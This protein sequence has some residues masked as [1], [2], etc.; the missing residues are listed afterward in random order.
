MRPDRA[1]VLGGAGLAL[2]AA[3]IGGGAAARVAA[4]TQV[5]KAIQPEADLAGFVTALEADATLPDDAR[6]SEPTPA[7]VISGPMESVLY[8]E[9]A[10]D[11]RIVAQALRLLGHRLDLTRDLALGDTVRLVVRSSPLP[12]L[13]YVELDARG[14]RVQLYRLA[15]DADRFVD[16]EGAD[17]GRGLLRT[18]LERPRITSIFGPRRHP[19]LGYTRLHKGVDFGAPVGT[20]VLAAADGVVERTDWAGDH[21]KRLRLRHADGWETVYAH[22]SA[23]RVS[24]GDQVRQGQV[25]ALTGNS[26]LS[27]GP[28]LH[29]EVLHDA[30]TI[31]PAAARPPSPQL[32]PVEQAAFDAR[33]QA[34]AALLAGA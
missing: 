24:P 9:A 28:H 26:G 29:F 16:A 21:G 3:V 10:A 7:R 23:W 18:P 12:A 11:P 31:D 14:G 22:L 30:Q 25:I 4:S 33:K 20:P 27:T 34:I 32:S 5:A 8:G 17:L 6:T 19:L 1:I 13:D 2:V 15:P